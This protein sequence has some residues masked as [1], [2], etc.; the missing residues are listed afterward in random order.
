LPEVRGVEKPEPEAD[1]DGRRLPAGRW[2]TRLFSV[3]CR[4]LNS[5]F[6]VMIF[7]KEHAFN[8]VGWFPRG[9]EICFIACDDQGSPY[10][11]IDKPF[12]DQRG[13]WL[14]IM[15]PL[16]P[17]VFLSGEMAENWAHKIFSGIGSSPKV[18]A[19]CKQ[20]TTALSTR[21]KGVSLR[22]F[23]RDSKDYKEAL[24]KQRRGPDVVRALRLAQ[25]PHYVWVVEAQ[26]RVKRDAGKPCTIAEIIFDADS[27]DH[28]K[29]QPRV[30]SLSLP[31]L[32]VVTPPDGAK[33]VPV[34]EPERPWRSQLQLS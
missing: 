29:R 8:I 16:P 18:T 26:D 20:L 9:K 33:P 17:K 28:K 24:L 6:P 1:E 31:G 7:T 15:V 12:K 19:G 4:Y 2:D 10:E 34:T 5:G 32:T 27:S 21:P 11:V 25:L 3:I 30:D 23:L 14:G 22:A 13:P